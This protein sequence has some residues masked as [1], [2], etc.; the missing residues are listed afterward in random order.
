MLLAAVSGWSSQPA[1]SRP[2]T[3]SI[4]RGVRT[5]RVVALSM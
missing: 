2:A 1:A 5:R 3:L 4:T